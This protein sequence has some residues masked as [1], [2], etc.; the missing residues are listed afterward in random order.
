[1]HVRIK[2]TKESNAIYVRTG[3]PVLPALF[4]TADLGKFRDN[5][6]VEFVLII[7]NKQKITYGKGAACQKES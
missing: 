7:I 6:P 3:V 5:L 1:M 2:R 4:H